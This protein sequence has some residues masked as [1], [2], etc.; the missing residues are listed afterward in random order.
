MRSIRLACAERAWCDF[1]SYDPRLPDELR[2]FV[3]RVER[4]DAMIETLEA[5]VVAFLVE[6]E[7]RIWDLSAKYG[8]KLA[9]AA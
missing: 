6:L 8:A 2:L 7:G 4:D 1:V 3:V 9:E 5:E